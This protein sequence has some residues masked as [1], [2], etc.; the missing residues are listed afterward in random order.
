VDRRVSLVSR[1]L[2]NDWAASS[3]SRLRLRRRIIR[4]DARRGPGCGGFGCSASRRLGLDLL[5][6]LNDDCLVNDSSVRH[7]GSIKMSI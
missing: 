2:S 5:P 3:R 4:R 6:R 1:V 7:A